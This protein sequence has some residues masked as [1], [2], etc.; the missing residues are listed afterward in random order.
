M[1]KMESGA[2]R[3]ASRNTRVVDMEELKRARERRASSARH[4]SEQIREVRKEYKGQD[5]ERPSVE[6]QDK[7]FWEQESPF[8]EQD[9]PFWQQDRP[10]RGTEDNYGAKQQTA[11]VPRQ[12]TRRKAAQIDEQQSR[13]SGRQNA[14]REDRQPPRQPE[15]RQ[16]V[17]DDRFQ[18]KQFERQ[19]ASKANTKSGRSGLQVLLVLLGLLAVTVVIGLKVFEIQE[20]EVKGAETVSKDS[21]IALSGI[22]KGDNIFKVSLGQAKQNLESDPLVEVVGISRAFPDKIKIEIKQRQPHGAIAYLGSYVIIDEK[23]FVVDVRDSLPVGQY[24][25]VTGIDIEPSVKGKPLVGVQG[26]AKELMYQ[27]LSA[28]YDNKA[29]QYVSE[30]SLADTN[31]IVMLSGEGLQID[32]GRPTDLGKKAQWIACS[33]PELRSKGYTSGILYVT[34]ANSPIFS[35]TSTGESAQ[36]DDANSNGTGDGGTVGAG[37]NNQDDTAAGDG[38]ENTQD[39]TADT[40]GGNEDT[41]PDNAA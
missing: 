24:P 36:G 29:L 10:F 17:R 7:P 15:R 37:D 20:I 9:R 18:T 5:F 2:A 32:I 21:I 31:K 19:S 28:L 34:G 30:V 8:E 33:V 1:L 6:E 38:G 27:V 13:P 22:N 4:P 12:S 3:S 25:L 14:A 40:D 41:G 35:A 23:G 26:G 39:N 11:P 16:P